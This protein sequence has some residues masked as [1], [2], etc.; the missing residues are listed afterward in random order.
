MTYLY[1]GP[2]AKSAVAQV[3]TDMAVEVSTPL[4]LDRPANSHSR[5]RRQRLLGIR[6]RR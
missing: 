6:S 3:S 4:I 5:G 2:L 1:Q